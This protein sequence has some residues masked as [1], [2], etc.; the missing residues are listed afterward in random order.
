MVEALLASPPRGQLPPTLAD[1]VAACRDCAQHWRSMLAAAHLF[2]RES[3]YGPRLRARTLAR[4]ARYQE[5]ASP[6]LWLWLAPAALV[7]MAAAYGLPA[8]VLSGAL[9]AVLASPALGIAAALLV[10][11]SLLVL[12]PASLAASL[13]LRTPKINGFPQFEKKGVRP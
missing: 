11:A 10:T 5:H 2:T 13:V 8:W 6:G 3:S 7:V 9:A 4:V 1:H 12:V